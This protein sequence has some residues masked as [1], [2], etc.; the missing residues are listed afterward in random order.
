MRI[1]SLHGPEGD[2]CELFTLAGPYARLFS[3]PSWRRINVQSV[4]RGPTDDSEQGRAA[5][6]VWFR[7][8]WNGTVYSGEL[9]TNGTLS[10]L[11]VGTSHFAFP[12]FR[13]LSPLDNY[14]ASHNALLSLLRPPRVTCDN[15]GLLTEGACGA[16][17]AGARGLD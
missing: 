2:R 15:A 7:G 14:A 11:T 6:S 3:P 17:W 13:D 5:A 9:F 16:R 8:D 1:Y 12:D 10:R 4:E